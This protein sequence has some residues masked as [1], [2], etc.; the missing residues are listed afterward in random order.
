MYVTL[1]FGKGKEIIYPNPDFQF[2]KGNKL[3]FTK[4]VPIKLDISNNF[5]LNFKEL[6]KL[7]NE[8]TSL[9]IN[10]PSNPTG[11]IMSKKK[12]MN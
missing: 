6:E 3:F 8:R 2:M 12:W 5:K 4:P 10:F 7:I 11:G 1:M 9:L